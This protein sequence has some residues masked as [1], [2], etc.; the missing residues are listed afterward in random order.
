MIWILL[1]SLPFIHCSGTHWTFWPVRTIFLAVS[2]GALT[3][4]FF[5]AVKVIETRSLT[6]VSCQ[7]VRTLCLFLTPT[8]RKCSRLCR[9][10]S[11]FKYDTGLFVQGLLKVVTSSPL[12]ILHSVI[13]IAIWCLLGYSFRLT[14]FWN[15]T[16]NCWNQYFNSCW[17]AFVLSI[18]FFLFL[19][20][21]MQWANLRLLIV[22]DTFSSHRLRSVSF[23][24]ESYGS[25]Q[26][27]ARWQEL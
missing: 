7:I 22:T 11:S 3:D 8:E 1:V 6:L 25:V 5:C 9:S 10:D 19:I 26:R 23:L 20:S 17:V 14:W 15:L 4:L 16:R 13:W 24:C 12:F 2:E 21:K 27:P 18:R